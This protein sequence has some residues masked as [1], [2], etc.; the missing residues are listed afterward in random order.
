MHT[1]SRSSPAL[2]TYTHTYT[3]THSHYHPSPITHTLTHT[4]IT[5]TYSRT[6]SHHHPLH[7]H[8]HTHTPTITHHTYTHTH[9]HSH[10]HLSHTTQSLIRYSSCMVAIGIR[11]RVCK[12]TPL[13]WPHL[14]LQADRSWGRKG[15]QH[16]QLLLLW[17]QRELR[18]GQG[19]ERETSDRVDHQQLRTDANSAVH[20]ATSTTST[21]R[22]GSEDAG[23]RLHSCFHW[24]E[25]LDQSFWTPALVEGSQCGC[26][27]DRDKKY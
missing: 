17:R 27:F 22:A 8:T 15:G 19:R 23:E 16:L 4:H 25:E 20:G 12:S 6:H 10:H 13:D 26:T 11:P 1:Q 21:T 14:W 5:L 18:D 2:I 7:T 9:T 24:Q 3:H